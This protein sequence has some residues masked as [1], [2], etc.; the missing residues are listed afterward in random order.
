M[1][2]GHPL[3]EWPKSWTDLPKDYRDDQEKRL[4]AYDQQ[5]SQDLWLTDQQAINAGWWPDY[6]IGPV[7]YC[8]QLPEYTAATYPPPSGDSA[9]QMGQSPGT[10]W[11]HAHSTALPRSMCRTA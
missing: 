3:L 2:K 7:P 5:A 8:F 1:L 6:F 11:Y 10:Q 4:K 9:L